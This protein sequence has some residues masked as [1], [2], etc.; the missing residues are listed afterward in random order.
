M[1]ETLNELVCERKRA[2]RNFRWSDADLKVLLES[3]ANVVKECP[4]M[5]EVNKRVLS[6][7]NV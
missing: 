6:M 1:A 4:E 7:K 3:V 2:N 5:F